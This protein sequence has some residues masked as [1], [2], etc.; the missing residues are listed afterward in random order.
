MITPIFNLGIKNTN[1]KILFYGGNYYGT[2]C[3]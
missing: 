3:I 2:I 1:I